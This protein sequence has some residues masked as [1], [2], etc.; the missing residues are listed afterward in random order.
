MNFL[1]SGKVFRFGLLEFA[2]ITWLSFGEYPNLADITEM[3]MSRR[4]VETYMNGD[5]TS[6]LA[7]LEKHF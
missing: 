1:I 7:D 6:K 2:L 4:L 5:V 3:S